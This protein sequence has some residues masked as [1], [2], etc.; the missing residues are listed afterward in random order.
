MDRDRERKSRR[1]SVCRRTR[2]PSPPQMPS[3]DVVD[4]TAA[5]PCVSDSASCSTPLALL[6]Q[7]PTNIRNGMSHTIRPPVRNAQSR[8]ELRA[9]GP[10]WAVRASRTFWDTFGYPVATATAQAQEEI[11]Q[12]L[13]PAGGV[14]ARLFR[15]G[16]ATRA[17]HL[18]GITGITC[19]SVG[20][21]VGIWPRV[22]LR[23]C[24]V[25]RISA[26]GAQDEADEPAAHYSHRA[27]AHAERFKSVAFAAPAGVGAPLDAVLTLTQF[28]RNCCVQS[29]GHVHH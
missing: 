13:G 2:I 16:G 7:R 25:H 22:G 20:C 15:R 27:P 19:C 11:A 9:L 17:V 4:P 29:L 21:R 5:N 14:A 26:R 1:G 23:C 3:R 24:V 18:P 28:R 6:E 10:G 8:V 12:K